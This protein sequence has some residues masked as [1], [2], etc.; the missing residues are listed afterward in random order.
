MLKLIFTFLFLIGFL[1]SL[2]SQTLD[3]LKVG[4]A[5]ASPFIIKTNHGLEGVNAFLWGQ[6]AKDL[7]LEYELVF[8]EF[9]DMLKALE[10]GTIDVSINPLTITSERS[11]N[12]NFT[13]SFYA[14]N[15]TIAVIQLSGFQKLRTFV[16]SFFNVNFIKIL[17]KDGHVFLQAF[18][19]LLD[20]RVVYFVISHYILLL[21]LK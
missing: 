16:K 10:E 15:S 14:S 2:V 11:K 20:Y 9:S 4:Y 18:Q 5:N 12:F 17:L 8:M 19:R 21:S 13:D 6:M 1:Q 3:T 7:N